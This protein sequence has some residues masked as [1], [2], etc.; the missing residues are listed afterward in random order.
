MS[1]G[2]DGQKRR[3]TP[4]DPI[5]ADQLRQFREITEARQAV[6]NSLLRLEQDKIYLLAS[7]KQL[8]VQHQRLFE[9]AMTERG[10]P[11]GTKAEIIAETGKIE[12]HQPPK[13][14]PK[15]PAA[16]PA[17]ETPPAETPAEDP[18]QPA[19]EA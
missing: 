16:E 4:N 19:T 18:E 12:V 15:Q 5:S 9:A 2:N 13:D 11:P 8:D 1:N 17:A 6:A 7:A 3:L 10:L 14:G